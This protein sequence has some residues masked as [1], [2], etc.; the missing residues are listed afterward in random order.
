MYAVVVRP[1]PEGYTVSA[2]WTLRRRGKVYGAIATSDDRFQSAHYERGTWA[3]WARHQ[4]L[5]HQE[6]GPPVAA[7]K[8]LMA[9]PVRSLEPGTRAF[10]AGG[11]GATLLPF[12]AVARSNGGRWQGYVVPQ[13]DGDQ[14][15][16][17][18]DL[19]LPDGRF[20]VLLDAWSSDRGRERGPEYHGL[21][22]SNGNDWSRFRPYAPRFAPALVGSDAVSGISAQPGASRQAPS[23]L[24]VA[25]TR[26]NRLYVSTDGAGTFRSVRAR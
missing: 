6:P 2:W 9:A 20:L 4:P 14:A 24:V 8:G 19:V 26:R 25:T 5:A 12:Q 13:T 11:D 21:W 18:G 10:V 17:D 1:G 16:D 23:G 15:Y 22:I 7:F 3:T